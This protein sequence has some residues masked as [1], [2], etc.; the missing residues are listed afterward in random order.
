MRCRNCGYE[1]RDGISKCE[2]CN[3]SLSGGDFESHVRTGTEREFSKE[4]MKT[5]NENSYSNNEANEDKPKGNNCPKCNYPIMKNASVCPQCNSSLIDDSKPKKNVSG[6]VD[7]W[8]QHK[9]KTSCQ[10]KPIAYENE[11]DMPPIVYSGDIIA[12]NRANTDP[13]NMAITSKEQA[14]L[15][16]ENG[17][18][19]IQDCSSQK[20]TFVL[21]RDKVELKPGDI[22]LLGDRRFEF[23]E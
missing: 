23:I 20:T 13:D 8:A 16:K 14:V 1:N 6:T 12:L 7:P 22:I 10:L 4:L 3:T 21:V 18:W 2:K 17:K 11:A 9:H 5:V 19:Y 15:T